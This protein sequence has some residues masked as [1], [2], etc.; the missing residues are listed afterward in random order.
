M[1]IFPVSFEELLSFRLNINLQK[2]LETHFHERVQ[3]LKKFCNILVF[4]YAE[5]LYEKYNH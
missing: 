4:L 3:L 2:S 5:L 1:K